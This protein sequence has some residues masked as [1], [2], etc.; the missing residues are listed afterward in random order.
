MA[1]EIIKSIQRYGDT[2]QPYPIGADAENVDMK[3][4]LS[5][6]EELKIGGNKCTKIS[7]KTMT[8]DDAEIKYTQIIEYYTS[9]YIAL[10]DISDSP[11]KVNFTVFSYIKAN[12]LSEYPIQVEQDQTEFNINDDTELDVLGQNSENP[13]VTKEGLAQ[14]ERQIIVHLYP[15]YKSSDDASD[16]NPSN[17]LHQKIITIVTQE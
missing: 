9:Q 16:S 14:N 13:V 8:V 3:S 1:N 5:L 17:L 12:L 2:A 10:R 15:G 6:Q 7:D 4:V 11:N